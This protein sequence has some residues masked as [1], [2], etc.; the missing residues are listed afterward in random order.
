MNL[1]WFKPALNFKTAKRVLIVHPFGLGDSL[2]VMPLIRALKE[3]G[4]EQIDLLLGS[5]TRELFEHHPCIDQIYEWDKSPLSGFS[6]KWN[7]FWKLAGMFFSI[8][9]NH[10]QIAFDLSP[11]AQ[12]AFVAF[13][14]FWIPVRI[15][16]NFKQRGFFLTHRVEIPEGFTGKSMTEYYLDLVRLAGIQ[17]NQTKPE[18]FLTKSDHE[19]RKSVFKQLGISESDS[20]LAVAPGGGESWGRD[21]RLKRW[22]AAYFAELIQTIQKR[23]PFLF[24]H[25]LILGGTEECNLGDELSKCLNGSSV[26]NLCGKTRIRTAAALI[27]KAELFV[28]NDG[29][30]THMAH[31]VHAPVIAFYGPTDPIVYGPYPLED[32]VLTMTHSGPACRPCYQRFKYQ[33]NCGGVECLTQLL[34]HQVWARIQNTRFLERLAPAGILS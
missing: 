13:F 22:P 23:Y 29:G 10:Y 6:G 32:K 25:V 31:A 5:R 21:A 8:W 2:F 11:R 28:G 14:F 3:N 12:Y 15:G 33:A 30:L 7:R 26:Y 34:P 24:K 4:A 9:K 16:F 17:F 18:I 19:E 1:F 27:Q 20:I